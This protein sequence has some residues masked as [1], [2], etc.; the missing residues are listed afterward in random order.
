MRMSGAR[1][2]VTLVSTGMLACASDADGD[3]GLG[4]EPSNE[5]S[6]RDASTDEDAARSP[7]LGQPDAGVAPGTGTD[8]AP[9]AEGGTGTGTGSGS[10]ACASV[11]SAV[12]LEPVHLAFAFDVSGSMGK[13]DK[14]WHDKKLKWEP[15]VSATRTFF[16]APSSSGLTAS[17]TFFPGENSRRICTASEY[18]APDVAMTALP[19]KLFGQQIDAI[20]PKTAAEWRSGTPTLAVMRGSR[21]FVNDYRKAHEG[22]YAVVLVTDGYPQLCGADVDNVDV[23]VAEAQAALG[24]SLQTFVVG[25]ANPKV[26]DAPDTVSDLHRIAAA[27]GTEQAFLIDTGDPAA[28]AST[29]TK[30]IEQIRKAAISCSLTIPSQDAGEFDAHNVLVHYR[31]GSD[32]RELKYD[33]SC[34]TES[35]WHYDN[36]EKPTQIVLC[37]S[38]C[39]EVRANPAAAL[40]VEFACE[41]QLF[42]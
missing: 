26:A 3:K 41:Q 23:V 34:T 5:E 24:E 1:W 35:A 30:A 38:T 21:S 15:V 28:T 16:E 19:S 9:G 17:L 25:V 37:D 22:R 32:V 20:A 40:E 7:L 31:T 12:E 6:A 39:S 11:S 2:L 29:F 13:G 18:N 8:T 36:V 27:G 42:L 14:P 4:G 33:K 10:S